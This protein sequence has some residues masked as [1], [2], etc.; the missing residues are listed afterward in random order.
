MPNLR[1]TDQ[2]ARA[3][4]LILQAWETALKEGV[5]PEMLAS[6][7]IFAALSDMVDL[8]GPEPV[9][10]MCEGLPARVRAGEFTLAENI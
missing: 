3:L 7:A 1:E 10:Q 8:Y 9:A 4:D 5:E 2:K 6:T